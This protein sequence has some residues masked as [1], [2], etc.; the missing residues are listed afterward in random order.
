MGFF[1]K[2]K[3]GVKAVTGGSA[4]VTMEWEPKDVA[5]GQL[6][7]VKITIQSTGSEV[8][9][10]GVF[11]DFDGDETLLVPPIPTPVANPGQG[12]PVDLMN[13]A[14]PPAAET[15][16]PSEPETDTNRICS[17]VF[18]LCGPFVLGAKETKVVEGKVNLPTS[19]RA[20]SATQ[21]GCHYQIRG[22]MEAFGNDPSSG[23]KD[24]TVVVKEA[25]AGDI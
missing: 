5:P 12:E 21:L 2:L 13:P 23:Y 19:L 14:A 1:D 25:P 17:E 8:K 9:S 18:T 4:K 10:Q 11:V 20:S 7:G 22:R 15:A 6:V 3:Q 16:A 24:I